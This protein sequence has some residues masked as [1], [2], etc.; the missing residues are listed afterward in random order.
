MSALRK[1][2]LSFG[3][4]TARSRDLPLSRVRRRPL[5]AEGVVRLV[6][7]VVGSLLRR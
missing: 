4:V 7:L 1:P 5:L 6:N 2:L 3:G